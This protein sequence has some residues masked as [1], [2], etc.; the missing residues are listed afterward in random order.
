MKLEIVI[1][2]YLMIFLFICA[3]YVEP[4]CI[5]KKNQYE[6]VH[7]LFIL[8]VG[9]NVQLVMEFDRLS[10]SQLLQCIIIPTAP[11]EKKKKMSKSKLNILQSIKS[12]LLY[13]H[14]YSLSLHFL[15]Q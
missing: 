1:S 13:A 2:V 9:R 7:I 5:E 4:Q 6:T 12:K 10:P 14:I 8:Q 3:F 11:C 15:C